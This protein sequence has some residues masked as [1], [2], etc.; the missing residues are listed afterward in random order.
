MRNNELPTNPNVG[1][2][3][4]INELS[5]IVFAGGCFWGVEA[6]FKRIFGVADV[7]VGYANG[8]TKETS[9]YDIAITGHVEAVNIKYDPNRVTLQTLI[10]YLFK[11]IDPT[12]LNKQ[13]ND[14][15]TQY[16]TGIYYKTDADVN[17]KI[18]YTDLRQ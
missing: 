10:E 8:K 17:G 11:I 5:E 15:G 6:F 7:T 3:Y 2:K 12:I 9:Y 14:I 16:R 1:I 4:D 13:G 18:K